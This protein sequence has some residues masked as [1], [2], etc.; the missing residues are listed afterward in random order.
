MF[1]FIHSFHDGNGRM[2]RALLSASLLRNDMRP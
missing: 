2:N 1:E